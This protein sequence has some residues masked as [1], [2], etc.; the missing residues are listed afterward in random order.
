MRTRGITFALVLTGC[1]SSP[2]NPR[3]IVGSSEFAAAL[4]DYRGRAVADDPCQLGTRASGPLPDLEGVWSASFTV[5]HSETDANVGLASGRRLELVDER[6]HPEGQGWALI[7]Q[8]NIGM[9]P[10]QS[11]EVALSGSGAEPRVVM[12]SVE[13]GVSGPC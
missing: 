3:D 4:E 6:P 2:P 12:W 5:T 9:D 8:A 10:G 7:T 11:L 1:A 13:H